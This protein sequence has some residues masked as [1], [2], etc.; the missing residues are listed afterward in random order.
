[1][2]TMWP[3]VE[4]PLRMCR[5][6]KQRFP[7]DNFFLNSNKRPRSVCKKCHVER[8]RLWRQRQ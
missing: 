8:N 6:C 3:K 2:T 1:M 5:D 7:D 4:S